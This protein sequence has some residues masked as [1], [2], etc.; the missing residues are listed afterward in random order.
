MSNE[1]I[2]LL[3]ALHKGTLSLSEVAERFRARSWPTHSVTAAQT[4]L[5][6][7]EEDLKDP[8]PYIPGSYDDVMAAY[9][10][11]KLTDAQ[12]AVLAEAVADSVRSH[13]TNG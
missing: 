4:H 12:Y 11:G 10:Q 1:V 5:D 7:A 6:L 3:T 13:G 2:D 8:E 9:D